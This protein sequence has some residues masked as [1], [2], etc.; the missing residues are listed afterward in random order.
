MDESGLGR[1]V[2]TVRSIA[3]T[4]GLSCETVS[5]VSNSNKLGLRLLPCDAF[6][7]VATG[8][9]KLAA[10]EI[11]IAH[12]L[13][14]VGAPVVPLESRVDPQV[15][16]LDGFAV[17]WWTFI[18][19]TTADPLSPTSYAGALNRFHSAAKRVEL[20]TPHFLDRV[21]EAEQLVS[22]RDATLGLTSAGRDVLTHTLESSRRD[23]ACIGSAEQILHGEPHPG[24]VLNAPGGPVF[25][26][27]ET[28]CRGPVEFDAAHAPIDVAAE[29]LGL[30]EELLQA[31]RRLVLAMVA[32]WRWDATDQFPD[33]IRH[34]RNILEL[35]GNG[36]PWPTIND[37]STI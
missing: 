36:P 7:R 18:D 27:F 37:L 20:T 3:E 17:T 4:L 16:E 25:I 23:I 2:T 12:H 33:G 8:G 15:H 24:N 32:A 21:H 14:A 5:V 28:C 13:A 10:F 31:C 11:A 35:L 1:A 9:R 19:A 29:Y 30:D 26:D 22:N 34:G 6:A